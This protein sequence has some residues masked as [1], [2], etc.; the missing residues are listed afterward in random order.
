[1]VNL[2]SFK[3]LY[4]VRKTVRF[5]LNQPNKKSNINKTH[6]QLKDLVDLSFEREK[7]LINNEKNQVLIDSEKALI[8]KLQQYVNG[9]EVQLENWEGTYQRY[10]L[11]A[12][13]KD[14]YKI[15]ARKAKFDA[16]WEISKFDKKSNKYI[17]VKQPQASQ[18][19]LSSLKIGNRSDSIIQYW[20]EIIEKTDYLLNI[21]KPKL[22]QY[23][24]AIND[25]NSTHIKPD[26]I[27]FR[28][29]FLQLLKLTK[30]F[31]QPLLDR[32]IIF[33]FSKKKVSQEIEKISEFAGE[34][35]NTKI[36]NVLKNG[37]ELRQYFEANGSQVPYGRVSLN[38]YT[39]VQK[40]NNFD[41]EIKKAI[42][43]LGIINFLKKRDSQIIDYLH[44]GSKQKIK[45]LLTS[46]SPYSIELLQLFKVKPIPFSVKYNLAKFIEKNYKNEINLSYEE[47]LDKLNLLGRAIDIA[48]DFKNSNNQNNFS[49]DE[50]PVKLA[51]DYAWE[52]TAR[53]LKRTIPFPKEV[54]KQFLKD[55]FDVDVNVDNADFKLYANL[56]FIA[57]NL[58][59]IEYNNPNNEA[60]LI[61]EIKQVFDSIDFSFDKE[62]YGGYKNDVLVLLNKAKPQ[63]DYSTIL[64]AKQELGLLRGGLKNKIK[65]Y[66]DLT[67]RLIDKKD[68][69]FG[70]ASFVGKTLAKIR[71]R[72][73][74]ENELNK[75]SHYG[76]ILEDKNQDKYLLISQLDGKDT[77]EKISQKFGNGD[78]KVYQVNS[79]TSK[80][81]NKF[82]KNPLSEDAKKFHGDFRYKHKE[83]SIYD[84]KGKWTGY[85]ES[86]L[87]H[88]KK[89]L[90][91]SEISRE[92]NWEAFGWNFAGCNTYEEIEKE[93][94]SKGYQ[95]T[96]NFISIGNLESLEKDEGCLLFPIINQDISSQKQENKNIFTLDLE[97]VFE[98]K[99][100]RIHPE[101]SIFYRK[102]MEEHKKENKSG[103]INRFGRLQLLANLGIEFI[104]R[105]SSFKTKK[106][107]NRIAIDQKKQ[108]QLVQEFNQ[109][110]V[111]TYFEGLDN[112]YIF[113]IDRGI[114]QLATLC[115]TNKNGVIQD[116]DIYTK[117]FNSESK[118]W[119]YKFHR[120]DGILD[121]T[122]L[123]IESDK[124]GNKYIVDISLFQAKD[125]DGNPTGTNKQNIQLKKL[126]YIRKLQYQ[127]SA[128]EEG[129]LSF[130]EKYKNKEEREQNMKELITPY[131][132]GKNFVD[133]PMDIFQEMF[134]NYYRLKTDQ[135]LSES[136]K[137]N[138]MKITTELDASES[139][140]KGVVANMIGV[141]YYL[142]KKYEYKVKISLEDLSNAWFFSKDGLSGDVVLNTKN[143]GTMDLKKQ[144][145]LALAGV[146]T[147]HFFEMQLLKKLFKISTEEGILHLVPSFGSVKNYTEIFKDKGKYVYKQFGI[148]YFVDPRN[149]SKKCPVCLNTQTTGKK[150]GIPIINR[151]YKKSN[152]F[153]CERCGFQSIHSHCQEENIKDSNGFHY[154]VEEVERIEMKNK[155]A[156]EKYK[157]QGKNLHFIKNGDD[158][159]AYNIGEKIRELPKKSDVK[160]T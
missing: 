61:N 119:E 62:R 138:L 77:R 30:E 65:K 145:N 70:I 118:K 10:D 23:E 33:E 97:K 43:D 24:R 64:K 4:E 103:I 20:G 63:R 147:Y 116:F 6:G 144:D 105:N 29:I 153:Y 87:S 152:I 121:L 135:N 49:L 134:E 21:F 136:E 75:I 126:A 52:N 104:P 74:E 41:Q 157:K 32:S 2:E 92:Q 48:N 45:L 96:E 36:Y 82:I 69:H 79:F 44:Q 22:E 114:K 66:R 46:K 125:E 60:E 90:I 128:N 89:C 68:S 109:E 8:E 95:L 149:T 28:K 124:S 76:V 148:V 100:C 5:G 16:M 25:A 129:V 140:K 86:F 51:F 127:M 94:D 160:N 111:N 142:M 34:K 85:Q 93:V 150:E 42:D 7:K 132:E 12:I 13:N 84:E 120:K 108:N 139:L 38:Y 151:N 110:K 117:H 73:K 37:E 130:L 159:G 158:N 102:P 71:D 106:E 3:N 83:V 11:I 27:D 88:I 115:I 18:I 107:Q 137:K 143:D 101:F 91:D 146:G 35:N 81:L 19:S 15:L 54:C 156:I 141:I 122:N 53:S 155:E 112:Y 131:K 154:S 80:A 31:L 72:L 1:M 123:K 39:A 14:Y 40:P 55:N 56:L 99:E 133:L 50:Y 98:G 57:D 9:L 59:T 58:A 47:I 113:G 78:I 67:Q 17:K 26:S